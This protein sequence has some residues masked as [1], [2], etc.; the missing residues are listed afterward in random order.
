MHTIMENGGPP[1]QSPSLSVDE[2]LDV[3]EEGLVG[4]FFRASRAAAAV[5]W[6]TARSDGRNVTSA[7]VEGVSSASTGRPAAAE[8]RR[9]MLSSSGRVRSMLIVGCFEGLKR[10]ARLASEIL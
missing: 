5:G 4:I 8:R 7:G 10:S 6:A 2:G 3:V 9:A 1:W